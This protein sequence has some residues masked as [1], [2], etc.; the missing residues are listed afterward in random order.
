M[1][2]TH[3][4]IV[5]LISVTGCDTMRP[6]EVTQLLQ[7]WREGDG[8]A[9]DQLIPLVYA[10]LRHMARRH[11]YGERAGHTLGTTGLVHEAFARLVEAPNVDWHDRN[12]FFAVCSTLMRRVLVDYARSRE[13]LKRGGGATLVALEDAPQC[14]HSPKVELLALD[15]ALAHLATF[16]ARKSQVVELR[17]FGGLTVEETAEVLH[18]SPE[19]VARD[20]KMAKAWLLRELAPARGDGA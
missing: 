7:A 17:F 4:T 14:G 11:M 5:S 6:G 16:D 1:T 13:Y 3:G 9:L 20:W 8:Q 12:H 2:E 18:T 19:T 10:E 15:E